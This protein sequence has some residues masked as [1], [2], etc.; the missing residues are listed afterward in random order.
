MGPSQARQ[1]KM[2]A[3]EIDD[4]AVLGKHGRDEEAAGSVKKVHVDTNAVTRKGVEDDFES[5]LR[6]YYAK[7][8][9]FGKM[10]K[11][12]SYGNDSLGSKREFSFTLEDDIYIR[13][14]SFNEASAWQAE[15]LKR[16]PHKMDMGAIFS[17]PPK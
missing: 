7:V 17:A 14:L 16:L 5:L 13:Y 4:S 3:M 12:M 15:C 8:F 6:F 1:R 9:P 11:W 10:W 2:A